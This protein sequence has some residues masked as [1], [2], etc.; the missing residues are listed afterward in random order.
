MKFLLLLSLAFVLSG[1]S[2]PQQPVTIEIIRDNGTPIP[3]PS[4]TNYPE[5]YHGPI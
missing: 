3:Y 5:V 2:T 1:C 4:Y